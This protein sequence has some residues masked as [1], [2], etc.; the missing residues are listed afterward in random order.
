VAEAL[1]RTAAQL[2]ADGE[3]L[4]DWADQEAERLRGGDGAL[5]ADAL[6]AL[7]AAVRSRVLHGAAIAAG[8]PQ[9]ALTA[10]HIGQLE[11]L[12]TGWRGQ[13]WIDLPAGVRAVRR[14][15]R[16][17]FMRAGEAGETSTAAGEAVG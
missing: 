7:P 1:A 13:R 10:R 8:C 9:G 5:D 2:R 11:L 14:C 16:L 15:G 4:S 17:L 12:V 3:A 6:A